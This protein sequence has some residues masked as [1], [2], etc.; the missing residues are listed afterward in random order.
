LTS[1]G[2][3]PSVPLPLSMLTVLRMFDH[4]AREVDVFVR[5]HIPFEELWA[6]SELMRVG[7]NQ[8]RVESLE[9]L[10]RAKRITAR[11]HDLED[12]EDLLKLTKPHNHSQ[13]K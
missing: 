9:H 3:V 4:L 13:N 1:L 10:L 5:Y 12:I 2:F 6:D 11:P 7:E 8:V